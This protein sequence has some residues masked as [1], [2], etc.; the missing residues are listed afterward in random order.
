MPVYDFKVP[1]VGVVGGVGGDY[2]K[3]VDPGDGGVLPT[4]RSLGRSAA[5]HPAARA[6]YGSMGIDGSTTSF[7]YRP[8]GSRRAEGGKLW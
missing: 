3:A 1:K 4:A 8:M 7:R 6:S 5:C 2:R